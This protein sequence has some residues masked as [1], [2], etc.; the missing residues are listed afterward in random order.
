MKKLSLLLIS[1][2]FVLG[3]TKEN[4]TPEGPTDVR[5]KN[6]SNVIYTNVI[7]RT[8]EEEFNFGNIDAGTVSAY[9]RFEV[10]YPD[11]EVSLSIDGN[12]YTNGE[13]NN[14]YATYIGPDKVTYE[15]IPTS[16]GSGD[17]L[18][19]IVYPLD[20]PITDL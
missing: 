5:I 8:G 7:V 14:T 13:Q 12:V 11:I 9:H 16:L 15:V 17:L 4:P 10:S 3:C 1:L 19:E 18:V 20:G 2:V 6:I